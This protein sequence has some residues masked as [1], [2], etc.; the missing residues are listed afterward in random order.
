[1]VSSDGEGER[2]GEARLETVSTILDLVKHGQNTRE[3]K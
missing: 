1:M 2:R 3:I